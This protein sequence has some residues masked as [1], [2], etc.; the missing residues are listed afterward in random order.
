MD[1]DIDISSPGNNSSTEEKDVFNDWENWN[2]EQVE[3]QQQSAFNAVA[4]SQELQELTG[5]VT[6]RPSY[7]SPL[8]W[9]ILKQITNGTI[10]SEAA[11][12]NMVNHLRFAK[13]EEMWEQ[14]QENP[15]LEQ[16]QLEEKKN[17]LAKQLLAN[18]P[19]RFKNGHLNQS[20]AHALQIK[21]LTD[22]IPN[23][24]ERRPRLAEEALKI[25]II[26]DIKKN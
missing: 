13:Q 6:T 15:N 21:L 23:A 5:P 4:E 14:L 11:L 1:N 26:F 19:A 20:Q 2:Q 3:E 7:V 18:I 24:D 12:T 17:R 8:E 16:S 22:L 9:Q 10:E 25:G